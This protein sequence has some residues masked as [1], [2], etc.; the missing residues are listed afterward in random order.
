MG[1][2]SR[3]EADIAIKDQVHILIEV[4][5]STSSAEVAKLWRIERLYEKVTGAKP[6]LVL[7]TPFIDEEGLE[8]AK[9]LGVEVYTKT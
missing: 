5:S 6:R 8:A 4:K 7:V 3:V 9:K 2:P 1:Y